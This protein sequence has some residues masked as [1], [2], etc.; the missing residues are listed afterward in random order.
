M[1]ETISEI[2]NE[3]GVTV[4]QFGR[5][6]ITQVLANR[7]FHPSI[8]AYFEA[9]VPDSPI[10]L[11]S[12]TILDESGIRQEN[13]DLIPGCHIFQHGFVAFARESCG[14]V[15]AADLGTGRVYWISHEKYEGESIEPGWKPDMSGFADPLPIDANN[16]IKTADMAFESIVAFF[17]MAVSDEENLEQDA[18]ADSPGGL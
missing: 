18:P 10:D 11:G 9:C 14:D 15:I 8:T 17:R 6:H 13:S 2:L 7:T 4:P 3:A 12:F 1:R 5:C 16:I